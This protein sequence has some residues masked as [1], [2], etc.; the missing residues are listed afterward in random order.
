MRKRERKIVNAE[1]TG[2]GKYLPEKVIDNKY[3]EKIK[4]NDRIFASF[5]YNF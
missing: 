5:S 2:I 1:I 4:N 3:F